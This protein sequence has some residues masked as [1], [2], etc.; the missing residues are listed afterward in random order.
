VSTS[1]KP[2][3]MIVEDDAVI[4]EVYGLK[5]ELEG[6]PVAMAENG[7]VALDQ[8]PGFRPHFI[9]LDMM[10]PVMDGLE[11][12]KRFQDTGRHHHTEVIIFSNVSAPANID[13]V[14]RLGA[15]DYWIKSDYEP[16]RV[17]AKIA[18]LWQQRSRPAA[19]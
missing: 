13:A 2:N 12:M 16:D 15:R 17:V 3:V 5:F 4:R 11:F 8:L 19:Q 6:Y 1:T 10:M 18:Q 7:A 14:M 9:L